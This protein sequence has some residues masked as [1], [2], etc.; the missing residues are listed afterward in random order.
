MGLFDDDRP[1]VQ[2]PNQAPYTPQSAE[3]SRGRFS[4]EALPAPSPPPTPS[5]AY[6][7]AIVPFSRDTGGNVYFDPLNAGPVGQVKQ[8]FTLP[9]RVASGQ[10]PIPRT[11]NP[12]SQDPNINPM[13]GETLNFAGSLGP[14]NPAVRSGDKIIPGVVSRPVDMTRAVAPSSKALI[15]EGG[16]QLDRF[17]EM[18]VRYDPQALVALAD[19]T[20]QALIKKGVFPENSPQLYATLGRLR[21]AAVPPEGAEVVVEPNNLKAVREN[22]AGLFET[23]GEHRKGVG[24][25]FD[26]LNKFLEKPPAGAVLAGPA[27]EAADLYAKGRANYAAGMRAKELEDIRRAAD[28]RASSAHSGLNQDNTL[29][30]KVASHILNAQKIKGYSPEEIA[31]LESVPLGTVPRNILRYTG[32]LM[33]G[34]GGLGATVAGTVSGTVGHMLGVPPGLATAAGIV[35]P[36]IGAGLK[37]AAGESTE[38]ALKA[39]EN[40]V[41]QR[42]PLFREQV[43]GQDLVPPLQGRD[44]IAASL[45]RQSMRPAPQPQ[46]PFIER[47]DPENY[48]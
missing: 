41:R 2:A 33:G 37:R 35:T 11:F 6:H 45:L 20:E 18:P 38:D 7:G 40:T 12:A 43:K 13:I 4:D 16:E 8:A 19:R 9:G 26:H 28:F 39:F 25:A 17:G 46:P 1:S 44:A 21:K 23:S 47:Y 36:A 14:M 34:G 15:K 5:P 32:N 31:Q 10:T 42:S 22:L 29:R 24:I 48:L 27:A 30:S 3:P